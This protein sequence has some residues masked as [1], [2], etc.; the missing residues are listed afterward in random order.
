MATLVK[1]CKPDAS[2]S[3]HFDPVQ[4]KLIDLDGAAVDHPDFVHDFK[5]VCDAGGATSVH[6]RDLHE[7]TLVYVNPKLRKMRMGAYTVVAP[8]P[9][10]FPRIKNACIKWAWKQ[11]PHRGWCP[12]PPSISHRLSGEKYGMPDFM[13]Q[14][15][16]AML[17]LSKF[18]ST[19]VEDLKARTRR[20][21]EVE[22]NLMSKVIAVPK[23][24]DGKTVLQQEKEL[25]KQR[26]APRILPEGRPGLKKSRRAA[27][28]GRVPLIAN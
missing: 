24:E 22:I 23:S 28:T 17:A 19:V 2:G 21:A 12:V 6:M 18:A 9:L 14:L 7:F 27:V 25:T 1:L 16:A 8:Y 3:V 10:E 15:E 4:D 20:I 26:S 11:I 13:S 5:L